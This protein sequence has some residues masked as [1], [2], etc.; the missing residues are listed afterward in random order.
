LLGCRGS[1][2]GA[3]DDLIAEDDRDLLFGWRARDGLEAGLLR[4]VGGDLVE[5]ALQTAH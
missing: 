5:V 3:T 2:V 4:R 1:L